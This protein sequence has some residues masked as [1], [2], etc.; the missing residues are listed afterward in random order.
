MFSRMDIPQ[1]STSGSCAAA[2]AVILG[3]PA[4]AV[5][6]TPPSVVSAAVSIDG[7][8]PTWG[9]AESVTAPREETWNDTPVTI[10]DAAYQAMLGKQVAVTLTSGTRFEGE[11]LAVDAQ[12]ATLVL[13]GGTVMAVSRV[14]VADLQRFD[15]D[16]VA[17]I[18]PEPSPAV[19]E[20]G[21]VPTDARAPGS[22][23]HRLVWGSVAVGVG[24][25]M[26]LAGLGVLMH[27]PTVGGAVLTVAGA[28]IGAGA[29]IPLLVSGRKAKRRHEA[30]ERAVLSIAPVRYVSG[31]GGGVTVRF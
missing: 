4:P 13:E 5:A 28:S 30:S 22:G 1:R 10:P 15:P 24:G 29:G 2:I 25:S 21:P 27:S 3:S 19:A 7:Q 23:F 14:E 17:P 31:W 12:Y 6:A 20:P 18:E 11:L 26:F 9:E 8:E 16:A